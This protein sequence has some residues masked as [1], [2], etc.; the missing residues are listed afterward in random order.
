V[1]K[2]SV[3][4]KTLRLRVGAQVMFTRNDTS[5]RWVNGTLG[6]VEKIED[7]VITVKLNND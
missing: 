7:D 4:E 5:K 1:D 6:K 2:F 3:T